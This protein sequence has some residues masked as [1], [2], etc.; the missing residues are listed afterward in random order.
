MYFF[1]RTVYF[2]ETDLTL[3]KNFAKGKIKDSFLIE[4]NELFIVNFNKNI[5]EK[6]VPFE[7]EPI[8]FYASQIFQLALS[9]SIQE[10]ELIFVIQMNQLI[11]YLH[12][13]YI[14]KEI[15][16]E[17]TRLNYTIRCW[18][19]DVYSPFKKGDIYPIDTEFKMS[20]DAGICKAD[21]EFYKQEPLWEAISMALFE[22]NEG[23][24]K[25][26]KAKEYFS[27]S[28]WFDEIRKV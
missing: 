28:I 17:G 14:E 8:I 12:Q 11:K 20:L 5:I 16:P 6:K 19:G 13:F 4:N 9:K 10:P 2:G 1:D 22:I 21:Q 18:T 24:K 15:N 27:Q 23:D 3:F 26:Q 7:T 25:I